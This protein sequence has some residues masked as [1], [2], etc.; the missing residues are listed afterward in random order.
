MF[1]SVLF[2]HAFFA[3]PAVAQPTAPRTSTATPLG[4][5]VARDPL[6]RDLLSNERSLR[7]IDQAVSDLDPLASSLR[8]VR[9]DP[10][11]PTGFSRVYEAPG[12]ANQLF[13]I[14]G[15]IIAAFP[16]SVYAGTRAGA[17]AVIPPGTIFYIGGLPAFD[18]AP[19]ALA[20]SLSRPMSSLMIGHQLEDSALTAPAH[21]EMTR[22]GARI[23]MWS[24]ERY[25]RRRVAALLHAVDLE[26]VR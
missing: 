11:V 6:L 25:R 19:P 26:A 5:H 3:A 15:G 1:A 7:L 13:R 21:R 24:D 2:S 18:A 9:P 20:S 8:L 10:R 14:N 4:K 17:T 23:T 12:R 16:R 22:T